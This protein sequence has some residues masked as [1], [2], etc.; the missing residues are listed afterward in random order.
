MSQSPMTPA[1]PAAKQPPSASAASAR[2]TRPGVP[3]SSIPSRLA[4]RVEQ[5]DPRP[6][7]L[8]LGRTFIATHMRPSGS[9]A[10]STTAPSRV[11][12]VIVP[13]GHSSAPVT[14]RA[15]ADRRP[16]HAADH[17]LADL[18]QVALRRDRDAVRAAALGSGLRPRL[19]P[20]LGRRR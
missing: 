3:S 19:G 8:A 13:S 9:T 12:S 1:S 20:R 17:G 16:R 14:A 2:T 6:L 18:D 15:L 4:V 7:V 5:G 11:S 10:T